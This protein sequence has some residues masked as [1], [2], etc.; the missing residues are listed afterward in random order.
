MNYKLLPALFLLFTLAGLQ[1]Q[2]IFDEPVRIIWDTD[3]QWDWD[4]AG[5]LAILHALADAGDAEILGIGSSVRSEAGEW[6]PHTIDIINTYY[7]RPDIP[8]GK[9][10]SGPGLNDVYGKWIVDQE[11]VDYELAPGQVWDNVVELYRKLLSEQADTS[12]V[13]VSVGYTSNIRDLL[14]SEPDQYSDLNGRDLIA[15]KVA[16]WSC[17]AGKY[18]GSGTEA[19][20]QDWHGHTKYAFD[21]FPRPILGTSSEAGT[22]SGAGSSLE[23]T[24]V[25]NPVRAIYRK[26]LDDQGY[27]HTFSHATWDPIA[28]L[29]AARDASQ[30]FDLTVSGTN[31]IT[32]NADNSQ[33][34]Q[35]QSTPDH[36]FRYLIQTDPNHVSAVLDELMGRA[37]ALPN[38]NPRLFL[39]I[40]G[41]GSVDFT[42]GSLDGDSVISMT[43]SGGVC[44]VFSHWSG[45]LTGDK[46]PVVIHLADNKNI[47]AVFS[48]VD[49]CVLP[50]LI[51]HWPL[52]EGSGSVAAD[53]SGNHFDL[54]LI[55][56]DDNSWEEDAIRGRS[57]KLN[58]ID[59]NGQVSPVAT[60][61]FQ[62]GTFLIVSLIKIE[63]GT[64]TSWSRVAGISNAYGFNVN[65]EGELG[66]WTNNG[67]FWYGS[68]ADHP[69]LADGRWH[70]IAVTHDDE[71]GNVLY[72]DGEEILI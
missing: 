53:V 9:S 70:H 31:V 23:F 57:L 13:L 58:G 3:M 15:Q 10:L 33:S 45:D 72:M 21:N 36:G 44:H 34:N 19:N 14:M 61:E 25:T 37:P 68:Y 40:S 5:A 63:A 26:R 64:V 50:D 28:T 4:D 67:I 51:A 47:T 39:E 42:G 32:I 69:G 29:V 43:A 46:N 8:I 18:P 49:G 35:W 2:D 17:M 30:Y 60:R 65:K 71:N 38:P 16:F 56:T 20:M 59:E 24:P 22:V 7:R 11:L 6:N 1:S 41:N 52:N 55:N 62:L 27:P 48:K 66:M 54:E 12:V